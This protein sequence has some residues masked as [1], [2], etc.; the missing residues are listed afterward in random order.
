M[1]IAM[2]P[3]LYL[4]CCL[5]ALLG[6]TACHDFVFGRVDIDMT[7]KTIAQQQL[8]RSGADY[9][10]GNGPDQHPTPIA[11]GQLHN[12]DP[13]GAMANWYTCLVMFKE[14]HNHR[15]GK[16]HGNPVFT[17]GA[18]RQE[19]FVEV[20]NT[21][22]GTP[23]VRL[24]TAT[25]RTFVEA[26][27]D[28]EAPPYVRIVGGR[29]QLWG[30]SLYFY[31]KDG[32]LMNDDILNRSDE[33]Q[34]FYSISDCDNQGQ[35]FDLRDVRYQ[36]SMPDSGRIEGVPSPTFV[37]KSFEQLQTLTPRVFRYTYRDTWTHKDMADGVRDYFNLRLL[38]PL[39]RDAF[40]N[41][42]AADQDVVGLKG[43][44]RF[45]FEDL[46]S[47]LEPRTWPLKLSE[48]G[49]FTTSYRRST[50][51]LPHFYLA[52][53]VMKCPK[54][55]KAI[56]DNA[57]A[58][59]GKSC[60]PF[61][62]PDARSGWTEVLRFNIPIRVMTSSYDSDPTNVDPYEPYF[63]HIGRELQLSPEDAYEL[64]ISKSTEGELRYDTW[65]L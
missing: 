8:P 6:L 45:H 4:P 30:C 61:Y 12:P 49:S 20:R 47:A 62:A 46:E 48:G 43:H 21:A 53:R 51:L 32:R 2:N 44:F 7:E 18:W 24:D 1:P 39:G 13:Q 9:Y 34:I 22:S 33:Y 10:Y 37:G 23:E 26:Q 56:V 63:Y 50:Y 29:S 54:G 25:S 27:R 19:Q 17:R 28:I 57:E 65:Y 16:L 3:Y 52:V 36:A 35:R 59:G 60:A 38:P 11:K 64:I 40:E 15:N 55:N 5:A 14:G 58:H 31:D 41:V 42:R